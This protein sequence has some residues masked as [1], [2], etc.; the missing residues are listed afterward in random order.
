MSEGRL[1]R[2]RFS[3]LLGTTTHLSVE[4]RVG[5]D[6]FCEYGERPFYERFPRLILWY[7]NIIAY[8]QRVRTLRQGSAVNVDDSELCA[9]QVEVVK[10]LR[11]QGE[12]KILW[13]YDVTGNSS[14]S[15]LARYLDQKNA[16]FYLTE[17]SATLLTR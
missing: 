12:R 13:L 9:W 1:I 11:S 5:Y 2:D 6:F 3:H 16:L 7:P 15:W 8:M 17:K 14:K 10:T 4:A